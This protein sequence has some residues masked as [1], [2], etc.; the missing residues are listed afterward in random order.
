[1]GNSCKKGSGNYPVEDM[2]Q[3]DAQV[4]QH[5]PMQLDLGD[6]KTRVQANRVGTPDE[7]TR[8][9]ETP[10]TRGFLTNSPAQS[11]RNS[12]PV[13]PPPTAMSMLPKYPTSHLQESGPVPPRH[14][15]LRSV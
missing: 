12:R 5:S 15:V 7:P 13:Q 8:D 2:Q 14:I 4:H 9:I 3:R 6:S 11:R 1:M 10:R